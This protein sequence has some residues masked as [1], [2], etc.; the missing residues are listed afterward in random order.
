MI[1]TTKAS[2]L[3]PLPCHFLSLLLFTNL[4]LSLSN[5]FLIFSNYLYSPISVNL[6]LPPSHSVFI[7]WT[8]SSIFYVLASLP[9]FWSSAFQNFAT[10]LPLSLPPSLYCCCSLSLS[11]SLSF[12]LPLSLCLSLYQP[13]SLSRCISQI[14]F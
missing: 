14:F 3:S 10:S 2:S 13:S 9:F 5:L 12:S 4:P 6:S 11:L 1:I 8:Y 7:G